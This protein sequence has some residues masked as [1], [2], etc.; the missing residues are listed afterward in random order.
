MFCDVFYGS[1]VPLS[2]TTDLFF[3]D[4]EFQLIVEPGGGNEFHRGAANIM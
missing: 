1:F 2:F 4:A 3:E